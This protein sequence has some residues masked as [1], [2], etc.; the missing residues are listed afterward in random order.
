MVTSGVMLRYTRTVMFL[1]SLSAASQALA[2]GA[3]GLDL[4]GGLVANGEAE[5]YLRALQLLGLVPQHPVGIRPW[6]R[7]ELARLTP[8]ASHPWAGT[9]VPEGQVRGSPMQNQIRQRPQ[10]L[11]L[12]DGESAQGAG[13]GSRSP[14][15]LPRTS[16]SGGAQG[17][18]RGTGCPCRVNSAAPVCQ[19]GDAQTAAG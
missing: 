2:Q 19:G 12:S 17:P 6:S 3:A 11:G 8:T 18:V 10:P 1:L 9:P 7:H 15:I 16:G 5:R 14:G 13:H 4:G